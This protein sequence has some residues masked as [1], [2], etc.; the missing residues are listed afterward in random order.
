MAN[1]GRERRVVAEVDPD[2]DGGTIANY[3]SPGQADRLAERF[4]KEAAAARGENGPNVELTP[5]ELII[6]GEKVER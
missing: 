3:A 4:R 5:D 6:T 1:K 2:G